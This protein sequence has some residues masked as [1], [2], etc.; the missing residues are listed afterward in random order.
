MTRRGSVTLTILL[1]I[2]SG[3]VLSALSLPMLARYAPAS[4]GLAEGVPLGFLLWVLLRR[5]LRAR[6]R[7]VTFAIALAAFQVLAFALFVWLILLALRSFT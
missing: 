7:L 6:R 2:G 4:L 5:R 1:A 3:V